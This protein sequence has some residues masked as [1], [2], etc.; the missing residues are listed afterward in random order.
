MVAVSFDQEAFGAPDLLPVFRAA[1]RGMRRLTAHHP[2]CW[3]EQMNRTPPVLRR[4]RP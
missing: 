1:S 4:R 3:L 2:R